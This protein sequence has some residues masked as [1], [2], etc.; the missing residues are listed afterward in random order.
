M[1][2]NEASAWLHGHMLRVKNASSGGLQVEGK[3]PWM[4]SGKEEAM[5]EAN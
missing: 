4:L 1:K 3:D 5:L 2:E